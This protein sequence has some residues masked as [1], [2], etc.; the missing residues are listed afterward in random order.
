MDGTLKDNKFTYTADEGVYEGAC[1]LSENSFKGYYKGP[2][3]GTF[4]M[5]RIK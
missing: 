4:Q 1:E 3:A 5:W 2:I